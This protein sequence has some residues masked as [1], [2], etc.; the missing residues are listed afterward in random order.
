[1]LSLRLIA[2]CLLFKYVQRRR[3]I[4]DLH[5]DRISP[6]ELRRKIAAGEPIAIVDL[7]HPLDFDADPRTL[8]GAVRLDTNELERR[9]AEIPRDR[10]VV[11]YCT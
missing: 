9:H 3:F 6:E 4:R 1:V 5:M 11:L 10:E 7:R 8:P 2:P